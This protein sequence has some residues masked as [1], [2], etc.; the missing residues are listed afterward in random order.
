MDNLEV[1]KER[2]LEVAKT[3]PD[4]DRILRGLFPD[5]FGEEFV[6]GGVYKFRGGYYLGARIDGMYT[7]I[8]LNTGGSKA[9]LKPTRVDALGRYADEL[10]YVGHTTEVIDIKRSTLKGGNNA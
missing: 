4:A 8:N 9:G 5:A 6:T 3:C 10:V 2:V 7:L 1:S